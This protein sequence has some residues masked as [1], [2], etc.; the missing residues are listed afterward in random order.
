VKTASDPNNSTRAV[1]GISDLTD[2][3]L[4]QPKFSFL[5]SGLPNVLLRA[6]FWLSIVL[7]SVA[8]I[9][10]LPIYPFDGDKFLDTLLNV[11]G[12][13]KT[14]QIRSFANAAAFSLLILNIG[15]SLVRFGFPFVR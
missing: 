8:L 14:K 1:I 13:R 7:V 6:E 3:V 10:M 2:Y 15:F 9:N 12:V 11:F 4:Y 5:S